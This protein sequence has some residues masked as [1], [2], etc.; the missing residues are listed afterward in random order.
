MPFPSFLLT[1]YSFSTRQL[2]HNAE[3]IVSKLG[4]RNLTSDGFSHKEKDQSGT[5]AQNRMMIWVMSVS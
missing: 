3:D 5:P 2:A 1:D 4:Q